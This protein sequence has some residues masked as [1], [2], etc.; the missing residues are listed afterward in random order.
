MFNHDAISQM[1]MMARLL[2]LSEQIEA[3]ER[4]VED[5]VNMIEEIRDHL[6]PARPSYE[7]KQWE[8]EELEAEDG[9]GGDILR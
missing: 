6:I 5:C 9:E 3:L 1:E 8:E 4:R 2:R 7:K